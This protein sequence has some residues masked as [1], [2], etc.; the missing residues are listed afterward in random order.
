M[1]EKIYNVE[2]FNQIN[3][4]AYLFLPGL[5]Y[6]KSGHVFAIDYAS[7]FVKY[8]LINREKAVELVKKHG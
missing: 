3:S 2:S 8:G 1:N 4:E 7:K 5:K 6:P